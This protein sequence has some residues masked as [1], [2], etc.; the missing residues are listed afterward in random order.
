MINCG[1]P[2]VRVLEDRWTAVT[3]DGKLSAHFE[4]TIAITDGDPEVLTEWERP[5]F[6]KV[7]SYPATSKGTG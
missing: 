3:V 2:S 1:G 4:H 5:G 6:Q 7:F